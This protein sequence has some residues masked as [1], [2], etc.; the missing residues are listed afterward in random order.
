MTAEAPK[1]GDLEETPDGVFSA[2]QRMVA[3]VAVQ[4]ELAW[5]RCAAHAPGAARGTLIGVPDRLQDLFLSSPRLV[6]VTKDY[7]FCYTCRRHVCEE[8]F[9]LTL[10]GVLALNR[11]LM[12]GSFMLSFSA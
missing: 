10:A 5:G 6:E 12:D 9:Q 2:W 3:P 8:R 4:D 7:F 11:L 1:P